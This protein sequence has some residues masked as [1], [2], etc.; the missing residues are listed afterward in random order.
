M[1]KSVN[2]IKKELVDKI[3]FLSEK[4]NNLV[5]DPGKENFVENLTKRDL[6]NCDLYTAKR[7]LKNIK[8]HGPMLGTSQDS[9]K[10]VKER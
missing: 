9:C 8:E 1:Y 10:E 6:Y 7:K 4:I 5:I 3:A 2:T